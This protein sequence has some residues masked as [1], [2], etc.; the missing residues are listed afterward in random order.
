V[1]QYS[2]SYTAPGFSGTGIFYLNSPS[3][4]TYVTHVTGMFA[5]SAIASGTAVASPGIEFGLGQDQLLFYP[6][7]PFLDSKGVCFS[8]LFDGETNAYDIYYKPGIGYE[9]AYV[10]NYVYGTGQTLSAGVPLTSFAVVGPPTLAGTVGGQTTTSEAAVAPFAHTTVGDLNA[11]ASDTLTISLA[12]AGGTLADGVGFGGLTSVG[13]GVYRLL[14]TASAITGELDALIFTPKAGAPNTSSTTTFTLSDLSSGYATATV[15]STTTVTDIDPAVAPTI[16]GTVGGQATMSEA[17]IDP[18]AGVTI[19]DLNGGATD[20]LTITRAGGAGVLRDGPSFSG[21]TLNA[22]GS[23]TLAGAAGAITNELDALVFTVAPGQPTTTFTLSDLSNAYP[24]PTVDSTTTVTD[25]DTPVPPTIMGAVANQLTTSEAPIDP[26]AGVKIGDINGGATDTLMITLSSGGTTGSLVDGAGYSGLTP[27]GGGAYTLAGSASAVTSELDA[28]VFTPAAASPGAAVMTGFVLSD[29]SN[30]YSGSTTDST[31]TVIDI[32]LPASVA[33]YLAYRTGLDAKAGGFGVSDTAANVVAALGQLEGDPNVTSVAISDTG[34]DVAANLDA[35]QSLAAAGKLTAI[36]L[37]DGGTPTLALTIAQA[38]NDSAALGKIVGPH[39]LALADTAADIA[40]ISSAQANALKALGYASIASTTGPVTMTVAEA[41][42]LTSNGIAVT[43]GATATASV[44]ALLALTTNAASSLVGAGYAFTALDTA[45]NIQKLTS[46]NVAS[47]QARHVMLLEANDT[48]VGISIALATSL[49]A[50]P[51]IQVKALTGSVT[52]S[53]NSVNVSKMAA[54]VIAGLP[55]IGVTGIVSINGSVTVNAQAAAALEAAG[56][57]ITGPSA[58]VG[59]TVVDLGANIFGPSGLSLAQ[60][61]LLP[62]TGA[63]VIKVTDASVTLTAA[64]ALRLESAKVKVIVP[65][66]DTVTLSDIPSSIM[67]LTGGTS[68][69]IAALPGAGVTNVA[70]SGN[71]TLSAAQATAFETAKLPIALPAGYSSTVTDTAANLKAMTVTQIAGLASLDVLRLVANDPTTVAAQFSV[72]Q[73][74]ALL[75]TNIGLSVQSGAAAMVYDYGVNLGTM[76]AGLT[77]AQLSSLRTNIGFTVLE[78]SN[79]VSFTAPQT[80]ALLV[81]GFSVSEIGANTATENFSN[82]NYSVYQYNLLAQQKTVDADG[83]FDIGYYNVTGKAYSSYEDVYSTTATEVAEAQ[84]LSSSAGNVI[85]Y[86]N[87]LT[88][89]QA[90]GSESI[91][92]GADTFAVNPHPNETTTATGRSNET[93]AF[94]PGFG[95]DT[96]IGFLAAGS[97]H[98]LVQLNA[99]MFAAGST[100]TS[101]LSSATGMTSATITDLAGDALTFSGISKSTLLANP[102]DFKLV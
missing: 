37:T 38:L 78:A 22:D 96:L 52:V 90:S 40:G 92:T 102:G 83:S 15:D 99:S 88:V 63:S 84:D 93:F 89:A 39:T 95:S 72:A 3:Y 43:G 67:A 62:S 57:Q 98:D 86:G 26:F 101:I 7:Q 47:L 51:A 54:S 33:T 68:G 18:F 41:Q 9:I 44:A 35:L 8:T 73:A 24:T 79:G 27:L 85:L 87:G 66:G 5:D 45:A 19:G 71:L 81:A 42:L 10:H 46:A 17:P 100:T 77:A 58:P 23:Y 36:S 49:E 2:F 32:A 61:G 55:A 28:L 11:G 21:L 4:P 48:S 29:V 97:S 60:L 12:G 56:L 70:A 65:T 75:T 14:G 76:L 1:T 59:V 30:A 6:S 91:T 69:T 82:G 64:Q 94:G 74:E 50:A 34:S 25:V 20:T 80:S 16:A 53:D 13:S 31:T